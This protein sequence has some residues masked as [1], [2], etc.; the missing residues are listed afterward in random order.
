MFD[1]SFGVCIQSNGIKKPDNLKVIKQ[2]A[3]AQVLKKLDIIY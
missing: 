3:K 2:Q 1:L